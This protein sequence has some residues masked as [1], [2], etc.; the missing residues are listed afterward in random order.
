MNHDNINTVRFLTRI[1]NYLDKLCLFEENDNN[2]YDNSNLRGGN[3][4]LYNTV[5]D[6][7]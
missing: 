3:A 7:L 1:Y 4:T 2:Y 5:S 6:H